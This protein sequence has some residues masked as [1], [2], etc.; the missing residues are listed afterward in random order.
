MEKKNAVFG[1]RELPK[2][3]KKTNQDY[4]PG[5]FMGS[6]Y[7]HKRDHSYVKE[8]V[9]LDADDD[10]NANKSHAKIKGPLCIR[11]PRSNLIFTLIS[12]IFSLAVVQYTAL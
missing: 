10:L 8:S 9:V 11:P 12:L 2:N 6:K 3:H 7:I 4:E 1:S 5:S